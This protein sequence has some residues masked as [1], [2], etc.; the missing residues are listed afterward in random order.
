M[1]LQFQL[2]HVKNI[3]A[4]CVL[5]LSTK[6]LTDSPVDALY[7]TFK[8]G[9]LP[10][11]RAPLPGTVWVSHLF[12]N[13]INGAGFRLDSAPNILVWILLEMMRVQKNHTFV[14]CV[15]VSGHVVRA[16][17]GRCSFE[18]LRALNYQS[19]RNVY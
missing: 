1:M 13:S 4:S 16:H 5:L 14:L 9:L 19:A 18:T 2:R 6:Y 11:A 15:K 3:H 17:T 10:D 12:Q 8:G 7:Q